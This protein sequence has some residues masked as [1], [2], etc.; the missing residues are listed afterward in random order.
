MKRMAEAA[1]IVEK[2]IE[3][4]PEHTYIY[5]TTLRKIGIEVIRHS[6]YTILRISTYPSSSVQVF[7]KPFFWFP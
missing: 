4:A 6:P 1:S 7:E 3:T 2:F 5:L